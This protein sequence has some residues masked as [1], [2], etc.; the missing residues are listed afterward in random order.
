MSFHLTMPQNSWLVRLAVAAGSMT[1]ALVLT[2]AFWRLLQHTPFLLGFGAAIVTSRIGGRKA[3]FLA[4]IIG[5]LGYAS[6]RP[7]LPADGFGP[8]LFGFVIVSGAFSWLVARRYE[9]EADLRASQELLHAVVIER[10]AAEQVVSRSER[11]LQ[12]I[13]DAEPAC[14]DRLDGAVAGVAASAANHARIDAG[15]IS[16]GHSK[17]VD[18]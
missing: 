5:A 18:G 3:G 8:L 11:R 12:A 15:C 9:I 17:G 14:V 13:I 1:C 7:P 2:H 10:M 4:V 6:F 16:V